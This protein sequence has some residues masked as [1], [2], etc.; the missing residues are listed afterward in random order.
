M[1]FMESRIGYQAKSDRM[2]IAA[3]T[4][5]PEAGGSGWEGPDIED[6][7]QGCFQK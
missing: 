3:E 1:G 6:V 4:L 5:R 7:A 2:I